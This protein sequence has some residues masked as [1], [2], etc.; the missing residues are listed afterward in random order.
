MGESKYIFAFKGCDAIIDFK[1]GGY[2]VWD[3]IK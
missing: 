1:I 3:K 2:T